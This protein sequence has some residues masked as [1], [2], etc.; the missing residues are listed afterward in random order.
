MHLIAGS[1]FNVPGEFPAVCF[2]RRLKIDEPM[3]EV[4]Q[5]YVAELQQRWANAKEVSGADAAKLVEGIAKAV[6]EEDAAYE[7]Y[8][9]ENMN[10]DVTTNIDGILGQ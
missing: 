7:A 5:T 10:P 4:Y 9:W 8:V 2:L 3:R 1:W 6:A